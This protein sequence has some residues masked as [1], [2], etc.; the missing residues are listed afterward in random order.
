MPPS[1]ALK[2]EAVCFFETYCW[3]RVVY[4][5]LHGAKIQDNTNIEI[6]TVYS[7]NYKK[8][9]NTICR[10]DCYSRF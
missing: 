6:N 1:S 7:E 10:S 2:M 8:N 5:K 3:R 9:M 4:T